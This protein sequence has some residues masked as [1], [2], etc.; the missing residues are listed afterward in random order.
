[1]ST[2]GHVHTTLV[3]H[4]PTRPT[5]HPVQRPALTSVPISEPFLWTS[6]A[7]GAGRVAAMS[8]VRH[9]F[10]HV[11]VHAPVAAMAL[12]S[13]A[14]A[15]E[16]TTEGSLEREE[17]PLEF[18]N[19]AEGR[20]TEEETAETGAGRPSGAPAG[21]VGAP[22]RAQPLPSGQAAPAAPAAPATL[23]IRGPRT[24]WY[25]DGETPA[26][27][28]VSTTLRSN[29]GAGAFSWS[30]SPQL[31]LSAPNVAAPVVTTAAPSA[32]LRDAWIRLRHTDAAGAASAA[33]Y[34]LTVRAPDSLGHI[35]D[36]DTADPVWGYDCEIHYSIRDQFA[37]TLPRNV[38]INEQWTGPVVA[39]FAGMDWRRG[40]EG[41]ATVNPANW[42]DHI[43]GETAGHNPAPVNPG[44]PSAGV[45]VYHW[46]GDW[47]VGSL[48]IGNGTRVSSVT[49]QK[50]RGFARH[51]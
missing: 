25:F 51:V 44:A 46:P 38:P 18:V 29:R 22:P 27:Y 14:P 32:A 30:V 31:A 4:L 17:E 6:A 37:T 33:S 45:A 3:S 21:G 28:L 34:R 20:V 48:T 49:W 7:S 42:F 16:P 8:A 1:M 13:P 39:D 40:A 9:D 10:G 23:Y 2:R 47:R 50:D 36:V 12:K 15:C 41:S 43:Q 24:M 5:S 11:K 26:N 19:E 35:N